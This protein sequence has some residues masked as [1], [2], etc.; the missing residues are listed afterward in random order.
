MASQLVSQSEK[1][2]FPFR[3]LNPTCKPVTIYRSLTVGTFTTAAGS[4]SVID[5]DKASVTPPPPLEN[6]ETMPLDLTSS[7]SL[8]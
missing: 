5:T 7:N 2:T 8:D 4:M 6:D 1:H 3:F